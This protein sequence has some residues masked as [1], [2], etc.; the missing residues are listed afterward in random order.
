MSFY[1]KNL[2]N[3][4]PVDPLYSPKGKEESDVLGNQRV[5]NLDLNR[6]VRGA[7]VKP[8]QPL[9]FH[10]YQ[11][12][13]GPSQEPA[14]EEKKLPPKKYPF[15]EGGTLNGKKHGWGILRYSE[16]SY[17]EG[18]WEEDLRHGFGK[19]ITL[20][21]KDSILEQYEGFWA[22][23]ERNGWGRFDYEDKDSYDGQWLNGQCHGM[24]KYTCS[25]GSFYE[26]PWANGIAL[27]DISHLGEALFFNLLHGSEEC[28][29][30][31]GY[32][33]GILLGYLEQENHLDIAFLLKEAQ[34]IFLLGG[35]LE[36]EKIE[37]ILKDLTELRKPRLFATGT[38][39]HAFG[40]NIIPDGSSEYAICEI[41]NTG[42]GLEFHREHPQDP[43]KF[44]TMLQVKIPLYGLTTG[45][46][47][48]LCYQFEST[49]FFYKS[50]LNLKDA[51]ILI[52][53]LILWQKEQKG[54][55][56]SLRWI[57]ALCKAKMGQVRYK[58]FIAKLKADCEALHKQQ[59]SPR[60]FDYES[61]EDSP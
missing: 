27:S 49:K 46:I 44:Q 17:Y 53:D 15:Y 35:L 37:S 43:R 39:D 1:L 34:K 40:V 51:E 7:E 55:D 16:K 29:P 33:L 9:R 5:A 52:S 22:K 26:G 59:V 3:S 12:P 61:L 20:D 50:I 23:D 19:E 4:A 2:S 13:I 11:S 45:L 6:Y 18:N 57:L 10:P 32:C 36:E 42:D 28:S 8:L 47:E 25:D 14:E 60:K 24:G 21:E 41:F 56:C 54:N 31:D 30:P 48:G 58:K 38:P